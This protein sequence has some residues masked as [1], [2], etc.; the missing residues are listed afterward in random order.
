[1]RRSFA[2]AIAALILVSSAGAHED[3]NHKLG[4]NG[5]HLIQNGHHMLEVLAKDGKFTVY[6]TGE[7]G[8]PEATAGAKAQAVILSSGK[9]SQVELEPAGDN[10]LSGTGEFAV[11]KAT[12]VITLT[13]PDHAPEQSRLT[14]E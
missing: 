6:V 9:K 3:E 7:D 11:A 5:G 4:P 1:M 13:M 10:V 2:F 12:A 8:K 14:F